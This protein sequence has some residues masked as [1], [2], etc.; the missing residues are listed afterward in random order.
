MSKKIVTLETL[1][2]CLSVPEISS[3]TGLAPNTVRALL[4]C[5]A[6]KGVRTGE[7]GASGRWV[8]TKKA[9]LKWLNQ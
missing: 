4:N 2:D 3:F 6:I 5:G 9:L 7:D 1:S 8:V